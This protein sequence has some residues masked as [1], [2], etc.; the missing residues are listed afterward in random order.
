MKKILAMTLMTASMVACTS[1]EP[2]QLGEATQGLAINPVASAD[3][4]DQETAVKLKAGNWDLLQIEIVLEPGDVIPWHYHY[5][6]VDVIVTEG[7]TSHEHTDGEFFDYGVGQGFIESTCTAHQI[8]NRGTTVSKIQ[9]H[10]VK[11]HGSE[12]LTF[13]SGPDA[14]ISD[15]LC[16]NP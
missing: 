5:G 12:P 10:F 4:V 11:P 14:K 3:S 6:L 13:T 9:V 7:V 15:P 8:V 16:T 2:D 1:S